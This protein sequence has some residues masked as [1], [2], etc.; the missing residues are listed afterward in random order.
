VTP[1]GQIKARVDAI[2][3]TYAETGLV[4]WVFKPVQSGYGKRALDYLCCIKGR[5]LAI[6]TKRRGQD[7]TPFQRQTALAIYE[8]GGTVFIINSTDGLQALARWLG[9]Q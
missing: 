6:E 5:M 7:L 9:A 1:E 2:L 3:Q 8:A 4:M